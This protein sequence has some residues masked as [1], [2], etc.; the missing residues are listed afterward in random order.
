[1]SPGLS[2]LTNKPNWNLCVNWGF[3]WSRT[4]T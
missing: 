3:C 4:P 1:L 2:N